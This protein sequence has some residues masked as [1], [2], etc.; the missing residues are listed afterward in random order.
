MENELGKTQ[1]AMNITR[2]MFLKMGFW[3]TGTASAWGIIRFFSFEEPGEKL[4]DSITLD[5]PSV[6][7][8]DSVL[9][10]PEVKAWLI[11]DDS[12]LYAVTATCTHLGCNINGEGNR[13]VCPCHGS[14]FDL[15]GRVLQGPATTSL[16]HFEVSLSADGRVVIDRRKTVL[17]NYRI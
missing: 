14:E 13:F 11:R 8:R 1:K 17:P 3:V 6:Y 12:G 5:P 7:L 10:V 2:R 15:S 4:L 16:A 9:F